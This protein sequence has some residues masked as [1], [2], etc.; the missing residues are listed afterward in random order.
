MEKRNKKRLYV[1]LSGGVDSAVAAALLVDAGYDVTGVFIEGWHP[2]HTPCSWQEDRRDALR[3]SAHLG[4]PFK[5][6]DAQE[7][8]RIAVGEYLIASYRSGETP[9]P[10]VLCN[11]EIKF[12]VFLSLA[13]EEGAEG[14]ATGHYARIVRNGEEIILQRGIDREKDQSYFLSMLHTHQ[15]QHAFFP[16]GGLTKKEVRRIA[17]EKKLPVADKPDSQGICFLGD[18]SMDTFLSEYIPSNP[19]KVINETGQEIGTHRGIAHYTEGARHGFSLYTPS[20]VPLYILKKDI[21][22][23]TLTV[24]PKE[25]LQ[26]PSSL[27]LSSV[28]LRKNIEPTEVIS[29]VS[30]Y[31]ASGE[32][33]YCREENGN[34]VL[35]P[36]SG[37][38][39]EPIASGQVVALY[40]GDNV[41]GGGIV[42]YS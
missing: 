28:I 1:G 21:K 18:I 5:T 2:P 11:R 19:G 42:V 40:Q 15:L 16:L 30:R 17:R 6:L 9:N 27:P 29:A 14:V 24:V 7:A 33:V 41:L 20:S 10:D 37:N 12:G 3:I 35:T 22:E 32:S 36:V 26:G 39:S 31:R 23:N 8:Y 25:M 4:I 34:M 13:R 38:F